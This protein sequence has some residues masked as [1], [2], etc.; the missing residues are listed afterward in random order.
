MK[1]QKEL[2]KK[3]KQI[4]QNHNLPEETIIEIY[5]SIWKCVRDKIES[6][7]KDDLESFNNIY[8]R[9]LGTF[10]AH[11]GKFNGIQKRKKE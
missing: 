3:L 9:H 11:E 8:I 1:I 10:Y 6:G 2:L 5:S 7:N 4:A